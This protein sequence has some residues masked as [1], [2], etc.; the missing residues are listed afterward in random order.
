MKIPPSNPFTFPPQTGEGTNTRLNFDLTIGELSAVSY[1]SRPFAAALKKDA[2][3]FVVAT[4]EQMQNDFAKYQEREFRLIPPADRGRFD[5]LVLSLWEKSRNFLDGSLEHYKLNDQREYFASE[6]HDAE[7]LAQMAHER[8]A[9][10]VIFNAAQASLLISLIATPQNDIATHLTFGT[11]LAEIRSIS[12]GKPRYIL[13]LTFDE[14]AAAAFTYLHIVES[15]LVINQA[16]RMDTAQ[17]HESAFNRFRDKEYAFIDPSVQQTYHVLILSVRDKIRAL[18][19]A[20]YADI[21]NPEERQKLVEEYRRACEAADIAERAF[22]PDK[23]SVFFTTKEA[24]L[25]RVVG[26][27]SDAQPL[28]VVSE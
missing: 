8:G 14:K 20:A 10:C 12:E 22:A 23:R 11:P 7:H 13:N 19:S 5:Q 25:M 28:P 18:I 26:E 1:L 16:F 24:N 15:H 27:E 6:C 4:H 9:D 3:Q 21:E 17:V 2:G